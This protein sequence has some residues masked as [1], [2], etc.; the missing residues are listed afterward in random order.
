MN[1]ADVTGVKYM[2]LENGTL[3]REFTNVKHAAMAFHW[4]KPENR[5]YVVLSYFRGDME[6]GSYIGNTTVV[7]RDGKSAFGKSASGNDASFIQAYVE[8]QRFP[9][10]EFVVY[11]RDWGTV[12][13][14]RCEQDDVLAFG[15]S[16]IN[17]AEN[18]K[19][20]YD[21]EMSFRAELQ[22]SDE[23][24]RTKQCALF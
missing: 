12:Y 1:M 15:E 4:A 17:A 10:P 23:M 20:A 13:G 19:K 24:R 18:W 3:P 14:W 5:P 2:V 6:V 8:A 11:E 21:S 22:R 9:V 7:T 16:R